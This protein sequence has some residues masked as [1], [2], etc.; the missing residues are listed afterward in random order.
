MIEAHTDLT[1]AAAGGLVSVGAGWPSPIA[2]A[3]AALAIALLAL[4]ARWASG[5]RHRRRDVDVP[6]AGAA[7]SRR[8]PTSPTQPGQTHTAKP[9]GKEQP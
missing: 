4:I 9:T 1:A 7:A 6:T 3:V 8:Q 5:R 2:W